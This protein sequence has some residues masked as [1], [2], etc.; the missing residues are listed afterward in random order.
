MCVEELYVRVCA[1]TIK[2]LAS[3]TLVPGLTIDDT[4]DF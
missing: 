2:A 3:L 1:S 4:A